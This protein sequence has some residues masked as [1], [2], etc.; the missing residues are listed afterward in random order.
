MSET[1]FI[2]EPGTPQLIMEREFDAPAELV[3]RA[4]TDAELIP[5]WLGP[6]RLQT[7]V[8]TLEPRDG[9]QWRYVHVDEDGSEYGFRGVFHGDPSPESGIVQTWE[10]EGAPGHVSLET[11]T[12]EER[13]GRTLVRANAVY[14]TVEARD[15]NIAHG[16]ESGARESYERLAELLERLAATV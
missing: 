14:Q 12:L 2:V 10:F 3:F 5:Q 11:L 8:E 15:A 9:G 6:R 4:Y 1:K 7:R 16:M 13:D